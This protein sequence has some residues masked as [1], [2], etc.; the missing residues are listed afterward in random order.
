MTIWRVLLNG[1]V[2]FAAET[3][4]ETGCRCFRLGLGERQCGIGQDLCVGHA[5]RRADAFRRGTG[6]TFMPDL[7]AQCCRRD[8]GASI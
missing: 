8:A 1:V 2:I 6:K 7:Y 3:T 4:H 5:P